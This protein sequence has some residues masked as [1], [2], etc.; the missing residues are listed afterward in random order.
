M[1]RSSI[2]VAALFSLT[3]GP[4]D[5]VKTLLGQAPTATPDDD[6]TLAA[7]PVVSPE[8]QLMAEATQLCAAGDCQSAHDRLAVGLPTNSP[9]RQSPAFKDLE[10]KWATATIS[11]ATDDPDLMQ[12]RAQLA[13]VIAS[14]AV[15]PG[16]KSKAAATLAALPTQPIVYDAGP[17]LTDAGMRMIDPKN[18]PRRGGKKHH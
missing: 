4:C 6:T 8:D 15:D 3:L 13:D 10:N 5:K 12:R 18:D 7:A 16:L 14:N 2:V 9:L 1:L 17:P 11:G